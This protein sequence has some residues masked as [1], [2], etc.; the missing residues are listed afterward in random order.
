[1]YAYIVG[2]SHL[3]EMCVVRHDL[4]KRLPIH[5]DVSV[6]VCVP[7]HRV[8][9]V[10]NNVTYVACCVLHAYSAGRRQTVH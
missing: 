2:S 4:K 7:S 6:C 1:M 10:R 9:V 8:N 3:A 5:S